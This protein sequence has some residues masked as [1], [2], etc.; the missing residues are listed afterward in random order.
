MVMNQT[1]WDDKVEVKKGNYGEELVDKFLE[2]KGFICY[3]PKTKG[4]HWFDRLAIKDKQRVIVAESKTKARLNKYPATGF[5]YKQYLEYK[6]IY[7][8]HKI[9]VFIF[10]VDE[11][12]KKIYG[13]FLTK[14]ELPTKIGNIEYP[15]RINDV[16]VFPLKNMVDIGELTDE[17]VNFLKQNS[18]RNYDYKVTKADNARAT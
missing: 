8:T 6:R 14:L 5:N 11:M 7:E 2:A 9:H 15:L 10:F 13:N 3:F 1:N 16:V 17:D 12:L 18:C 4:A